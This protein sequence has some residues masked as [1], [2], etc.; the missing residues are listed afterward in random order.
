MTSF[1]KSPLMTG[2]A[3]ETVSSNDQRQAVEII[4]PA[5][6]LKNSRYVH[7]PQ[8][9]CRPLRQTRQGHTA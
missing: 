5:A 2:T 1:L 6:A 7:A 9:L 3:P 8:D 4:E